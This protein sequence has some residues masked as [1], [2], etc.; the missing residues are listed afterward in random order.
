[1][2]WK[3]PVAEVVPSG[4]SH[5]T[6]EENIAASLFTNIAE[7]T[8]LDFVHSAGDLSEYFFPSIMCGGCAL[9]DFDRDGRLDIYLVNGND[10]R[11]NDLIGRGSMAEAAQPVNRL[12]RQTQHG[13]FEDVTETSGLGDA[14]FGMGVSVGDVNNDGF[15]D[16]YVTNYGADQLYLNQQDG[17]FANVTKE[18]GINNIHWSA[19]A[20]FVDFDRDGWLDLYVTNYVDYYTERNCPD[21]NGQSEFCGP[22]TFFPVADKLFRN[23]TGEQKSA[24]LSGHEPRFLDVSIE[25]GITGKAASGLGVVCADFNDDLWP[26]IY[27]A[28]DRMANHLWI[29]Q[30]GKS[31]V[32]EAV[33]RGVAFDSQGRPQAGMGIGVGDVN[34]DALTD[35]YVTH[36]E[37]E[38]NALY[39]SQGTGVFGEESA[40]TGLFAPTFP[41]TGFG[42]ALIDIDHNTHPDIVVVNGRVKRN[43]AAQGHANPD[44]SDYAETNMIFLNSGDGKWT[45]PGTAEAFCSA[46][47]VS[48][49]LAT[50]DIDNDGDLDLLVTHIGAAPGLFRNDSQTT[51]A[52][53]KVRAVDPRYGGRDV[54]G[55]RVTVVAGG[56]RWSATVR[57]GG[58][59]LSASDPVV[60][61]GMG[62]A[63]R[64]DRIQIIWADG[65]SEVFEGGPVNE[66]RVIARDTGRRSDDNS[67]L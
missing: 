56:S 46:P 33:F 36:M 43:G 2:L 11:A 3:Q 23:V 7:S 31:F 1:M 60:H 37:G 6:T 29:N 26:D 14:G 20:T 9:F 4:H 27:V 58:S 16:V 64:I 54:Y 44:W 8:G 21:L 39:L 51:W 63:E 12:F 17:T 48:R 34:G 15:S 53:L 67:G 18:S 25:C 65:V 59:Y 42:T 40:R 49:G 22:Q 45:Q 35:L 61:F 52:W 38:T 66:T 28:N 19:S 41:F 13:T 55:A 50:G 47:Q 30:Q 57:S 32:D 10:L 62:A 5:V 24:D